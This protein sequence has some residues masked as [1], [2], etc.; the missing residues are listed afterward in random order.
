M[1]DF[2]RQNVGFFSQ[3]H[4]GEIGQLRAGLAVLFV[5]SG[6]IGQLCAGFIS[7]KSCKLRNI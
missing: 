4:S 2:V 5:H 3:P 6:E 1:E 7:Q